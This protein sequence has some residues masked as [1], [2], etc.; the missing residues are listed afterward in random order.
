MEVIGTIHSAE[1]KRRPTRNAYLVAEHIGKLGVNK[2]GIEGHEVIVGLHMLRDPRVRFKQELVGRLKEK[3]VQVV[4]LENAPEKLAEAYLT[5]ALIGIM[6]TGRGMDKQ[7]TEQA[8]LKLSMDRRSRIESR[9]HQGFQALDTAI[10]HLMNLQG[11]VEEIAKSRSPEFLGKL[12]DALMVRRSKTM[13]SEAQ[14]QGL[15]AI[16]VGAM[17]AS[18][19]EELNPEPMSATY[20]TKMFIQQKKQ[21]TEGS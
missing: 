1:Y 18:H 21:D 6:R 9:D 13:L 8:R 19:L 3:G 7:I 5:E 20:L 4:H 11:K 2:V 16:V 14:K 12:I 17:H 15:P 10:E